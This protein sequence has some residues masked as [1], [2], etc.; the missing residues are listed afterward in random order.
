MSTVTAHEFCTRCA[1]GPP[2]TLTIVGCGPPSVVCVHRVESLESQCVLGFLVLC[3]REPR[4]PHAIQ[5]PVRRLGAIPPTS[6]W[7]A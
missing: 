3:G 4:R 7:T 6:A 5:N 2:Y 1:C